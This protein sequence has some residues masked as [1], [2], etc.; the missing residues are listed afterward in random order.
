MSCKWIH[1]VL[2]LAI[3]IF[4]FVDSS[5]S[6]WIIVIAALALLIHALMCKHCNA[7]WSQHGIKEMPM[8]S[9]RKR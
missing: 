4:A 6:Q 9:K 3:V 5:V 7:C 8:P 1:V 2:L